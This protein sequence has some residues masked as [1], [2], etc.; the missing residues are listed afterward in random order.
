MTARELP[1]GT[2][3]YLGRYWVGQLDTRPFAFFRILFGLVLLYDLCDLLP[4]LRTFFS[5]EGVL[6]RVP[7]LGQWARA[8]RFCLLDAFG[9][10]QLVYVFW[11]ISAAA[12]VCFILGYR[13]R[14]ASVVA[15]LALASFQERLPPLFDGSDT[16]IRM[17]LFWHIF[18]ATNRVWSVDALLAQKKGEPLSVMAPA[19]PFR[20]MQ[21][22]IALIYL[23]TASHKVQGST[24]RGGDAVHYCLHLNH[25]FSR[26]WAA[27]PWFADSAF[28]VGAQT[29]G[30]L[31]F[32]FA[33]TGLVFLP[34][35]WERVFKGAKA[36]GLV[37]ITALHVGIAFTINVGLFSYLMPLVLTMFWEPEWTQLAMDKI[38]ARL[39]PSRLAR[40]E[41]IASRFPVSRGWENP[42]SELVPAGI[43]RATARL[44]PVALVVW[45]VLCSWYAVP[46]YMR[47]WLGQQ[48]S[49]PTV[50]MGL[51]AVNPMPRWIEVP[52]QALDV[53]SSWDMFSPEPLRTDY[54]LT[55]PG[56]LDDGSQINLFESPEGEQRGFW[57]TRWYKYF[58]NV[59]GGDQLL[60]LEWGRFMCR[61]RNFAAVSPT[62]RLYT[63]TLWKDN[64]V[65]PPIGQPWPPVTRQKVWEHRCYDRPNPPPARPSNLPVAAQS[66]PQLIPA[67]MPATPAVRSTP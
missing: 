54:H 49:G 2:K 23:I 13:T 12:A 47:T 46:P 52:V 22:Q 62:Q 39:G 36:L 5:D 55:A 8:A 1:A 33:F 56:E 19:L 57:F 32:E 31:V 14:V 43:K 51:G 48:A 10:P 3:T 41:E 34:V 9:T 17:T 6:P 11:A 26:D 16:V 24:W 35:P 27:A 40:V 20:L 38:Q 45:F 53:W 42:P 61:E 18:C 65:I 63:F 67:S 59:T 4:N 44:F 58:E 25:V 15:F 28:L 21:I 29:I 30:T 60:P 37:S 66:T 64:Q 7:F 50:A